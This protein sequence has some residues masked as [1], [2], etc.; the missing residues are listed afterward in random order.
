MALARSQRSTIMSQPTPAFHHNTSVGSTPEPTS[1]CRCRCYCDPV[2]R[3]KCLYPSGS[4]S[5]YSGTQVRADGSVYVDLA[6]NHPG[7]GDP[8]YE[9]RRAEIAGISN[10][11]QPGQEPLT[12]EYT[13][14]ENRVWAECCTVLDPLH[15]R[16]ACQ[17]YLDGK[18]RLG[19]PT[20]RVPQLVEVNELLAR[21]KATT[22]STPGIRFR[23]LAA[24]GLCR[25]VSSMRRWG[26][27]SFSPP[28]T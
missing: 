15:D 23:Y 28:S 9:S 21:A 1:G 13:D 27:A 26:L 6:S 5:V 18:A 19:L 16:Y 11:W 10:T 25:C 17:E 14:D 7:K 4:S 12:V 8:A 22:R 3:C 2:C 24:P 20:D